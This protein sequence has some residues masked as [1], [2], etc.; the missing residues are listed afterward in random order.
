[1]LWAIPHSLA[2]Q[3]HRHPFL[4]SQRKW[5]RCSSSCLISLSFYHYILNFYNITFGKISLLYSLPCWVTTH[6]LLC[7]ISFHFYPWLFRV[8]FPFMQ[9]AYTLH[10]FYALWEKKAPRQKRRRNG[11]DIRQFNFLKKFYLKSFL[12]I[13]GFQNS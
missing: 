8:W 10:F 1:M 9:F 3:V 4:T 5:Q 2:I 13:I 6:L 7:F 12:R 11:R